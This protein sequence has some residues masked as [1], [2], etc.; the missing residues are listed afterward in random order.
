MRTYNYAAA[1]AYIEKNRH[2]ISTASLG[3]QEDW[4]WTAEKV[5]ENDTYSIDLSDCPFIAGIDSSNWA[6]PALFVEFSDGSPD[7]MMACYT[8]EQ[9]RTSGHPVFTS[10]NQEEVSPITHILSAG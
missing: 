4:Y 1:I 10:P 5:F 8:G 3:M 6:T 9:D 7:E 2:R